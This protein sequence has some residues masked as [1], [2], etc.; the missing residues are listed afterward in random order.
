MGNWRD[1]RFPC[2]TMST[3]LER[4]CDGIAGDGEGWGR[5]LEFEASGDDDFGWDD[6]STPLSCRVGVCA[7][8][9]ESTR[10]KSKIESE[11]LM[12]WPFLRVQRMV[13]RRTRRASR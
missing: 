6:G 7:P 2:L 11:L 10:P 13:E 12:P 3:V 1:K 4:E 5:T 8:S 9:M